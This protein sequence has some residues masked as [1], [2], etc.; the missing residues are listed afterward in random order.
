MNPDAGLWVVVPAAGRGVRAGG[1]IPKQYQLLLGRPMIEH[2]LRA[3]ASHPRVAGL[4]VVLATD[5]AFWPGWTELEGTPVIVTTGGAERADSVLAGLDALP[6]TLAADAF[7]LVHDAARPCITHRDIDALL[8][9][10]A[11]D[12][13]LLAV[14]LAD[15]LKRAGRQAGEQPRASE[16][17]PR[18]G[19]WRALTPQRF[20]RQALVRALRMAAS[21]KLAV[22]DESM[23][24]ERAGF[25]P[26]LVEGAA[27]NIKVTTAEDFALAE[28]LLQHRDSPSVS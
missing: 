19:L 9:A 28:F 5:D 11:P 8:D 18:E 21:E 15:T 1:E 2:T 25:S 26:L 12:G 20:P 16:T 6:T 10:D 13:A 23:A 4:V 22:T 7:V 27:D 17:V 14:P 3:L 24:M